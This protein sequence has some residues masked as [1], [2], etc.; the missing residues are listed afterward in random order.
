M[1][2]SMGVSSMIVGVTSRDED[3]EKQAFMKS[4]LNDCYGKPLNAEK[5]TAMLEKLKKN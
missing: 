1:L 4:G 2:R 3:S 5:V